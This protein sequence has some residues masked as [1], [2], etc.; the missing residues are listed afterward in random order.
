MEKQLIKINLRTLKIYLG[1]CVDGDAGLDVEGIPYVFW[2]GEWSPIC[3]HYFWNSQHGAQ[4]FCQKLGYTTGT[5]KREYSEYCK[6]A[7]E[8]G[9]CRPGETIDS[10]TGG[11]N[12]YQKTGWCSAGNSVKITIACNGNPQGSSLSTC[13]VQGSELSD[14]KGKVKVLSSIKI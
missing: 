3:G 7:I 14:C 4:A 8:I 10:C 6:D 12:K 1:I 13:N 11:S 5:Y 2:S 9:V